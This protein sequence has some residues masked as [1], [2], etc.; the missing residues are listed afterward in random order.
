[1]KRKSHDSGRVAWPSM[2]NSSLRAALVK[3]YALALMLCRA[4][5][6]GLLL[7]PCVEAQL[8]PSELVQLCSTIGAHAGMAM[9]AHA[10]FGPWRF[11]FHRGMT[12]S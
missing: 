3:L 4:A 10:G 5:V 7:L 11:G 12:A 9:L 2:S 8:M 6:G 1:M